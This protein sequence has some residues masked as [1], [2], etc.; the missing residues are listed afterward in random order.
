[1][2]GSRTFR[3]PAHEMRESSTDRSAGRFDLGPERGIISVPSIE[4]G[5][6]VLGIQVTRG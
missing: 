2:L 3:S 4:K 5:R 6:P 1:M